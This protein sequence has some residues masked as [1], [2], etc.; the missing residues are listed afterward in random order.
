MKKLHLLFCLFSL[1]MLA[2]ACRNEVSPDNVVYITGGDAVSTMFDAIVTDCSVEPLISDLPLDASTMIV[3]GNTILMSN[4]DRSQL[5]FLQ[6]NRLVSELSAKGRGPGEYS[7]IN[8]FTYCSESSVVFLSSVSKQEVLCYD[9]QTMKYIGC[10][11]SDCFVSEMCVLDDSTLLAVRY[12]DGEGNYLAAV[13]IHTGESE[14]LCDLSQ[15]ESSMYFYPQSDSQYKIAY[16]ANNYISTIS[17]IGSDDACHELQNFCFTDGMPEEMFNQGNEDDFSDESLNYLEYSFSEHYYGGIFMPLITDDGYTFWYANHN[18]PSQ[19]SWDCL[20]HKSGDRI[21]Q[22]K[23]I[24]IPGIK[25][26]IEPDGLTD[27]GRYFT[28]FAGTSDMFEDPGV[29]P[30]DL[31]RQILDAVDAQNECNPVVLFYRIK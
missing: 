24:T 22:A 28:V 30:S 29:E 21:I 13:D 31:A 2:A 14:K 11:P 27:D 12:L 15:T 5:Q 4:S 10:V 25:N 9:A 26:Y 6:N 8:S 1:L 16:S 20:Y 23:N 3:H 19:D 17:Y 7:M 18:S